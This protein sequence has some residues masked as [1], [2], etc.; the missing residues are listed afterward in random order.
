MTSSTSPDT[1]NLG[2]IRR[3]LA[4]PLVWFV[5][6]AVVIIA[7]DQVIRVAA[8]GFGAPIRIV[9]SLVSAA[10]AIGIYVLTMRLLAR[11][12]TPELR[13]SVFREI[14]LGAAIGAFF[15]ISSVLVIAALGGYSV[16]WHP[17]DALNTVSL[18]I[19]FNFGVAIVEEL[20]FRG[21]ALQAIEKLGGPWIAIAVTALLFGGAHLLN[22]NATPWSAL[23]IALEAGV[24]IGAAFVWRRSLWFV[25]GL[26]F[27]WN[28]LVSLL[29]IPV[30]GS[31]KP[32]LFATTTHGPDWL[33]GGAF[34][35]EA[36]VITVAVGV[37][38]STVMIIAA[39]RTR[40][41]TA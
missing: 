7:V 31:R 25:I 3:F 4:F 11:R 14:L 13:G 6:G 29:G 1:K 18:A 22:A 27:A 33:T 9:A 21:L 32:G 8:S 36:S 16:Q 5:L 10:L 35:I 12:R 34:G 38:V 26:H 20:A 30:S 39:V 40:R 17:I 28:T 23:A 19:V 24:L 15:V 2:I 37:V 41:V